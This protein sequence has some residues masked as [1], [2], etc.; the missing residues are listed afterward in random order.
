MRFAAANCTPNDPWPS[1]I[2][3]PTLS[4]KPRIALPPVLGISHLLRQTSEAARRNLCSPEEKVA[5][6]ASILSGEPDV[7]Q[8]VENRL[9]QLLQNSDGKEE[10]LLETK[11]ESPRG[12]REGGSRGQ[13]IVNDGRK[14]VVILRGIPGTPGK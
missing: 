9:S 13:V 1:S 12:Q 4:Q 6:K 2:P 3:E 14:T 8:S 11:E 7:V 5:F 10:T